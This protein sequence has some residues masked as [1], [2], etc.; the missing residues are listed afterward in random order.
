M[1][2]KGPLGGGGVENGPLLRTQCRARVVERETGRLWAHRPPVSEDT[3]CPPSE[4]PHG[5]RCETLSSHVLGIGAGHDGPKAKRVPET[6]ETVG[7]ATPSPYGSVLGP[8]LK[9]PA[10]SPASSPSRFRWR[11]RGPDPPLFFTRSYW[12]L[13]W[14]EHFKSQPWPRVL[15][16]PLRE[17]A[18]ADV[19]RHPHGRP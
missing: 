2:P 19:Q 5:C 3:N 18:N 10:S 12:L 8:P 14:T 6:G 1:S 15:L 4:Q 9:Q 13:S 16:C 11:S 17:G 7:F